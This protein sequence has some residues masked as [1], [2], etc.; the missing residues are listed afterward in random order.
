L[1]KGNYTAMVAHPVDGDL[2]SCAGL[3][4]AEDRDMIMPNF[5]AYLVYASATML[6]L[7]AIVSMVWL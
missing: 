4:L 1:K 7:L 5:F 2:L 3:A 6:P